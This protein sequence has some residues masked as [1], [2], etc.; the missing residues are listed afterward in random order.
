[1]VLPR[2]VAFVAGMQRWTLRHTNKVN[3]FVNK[4]MAHLV[5]S[6]V[7]SS[8]S[9]VANSCCTPKSEANSSCCPPKVDSALCPPKAELK[10][11]CGPLETENDNQSAPVSEVTHS[12]VSEYYGK[13]IQ[14]TTDLL[15][16]AC[17]LQVL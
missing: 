8:K 11:C 15:T 7:P 2:V 9:N 16:S 1:M 5:A 12:D 6:G 14:A 10:S 13:T 3:I 4:R 17:V